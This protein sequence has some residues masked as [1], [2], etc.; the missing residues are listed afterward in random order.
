MT[1]IHRRFLRGVFR[2][3]LVGA[4]L[5][6]IPYAVFVVPDG[7]II[8]AGD[9][10]G[11]QLPAR[12][13]AR[14][15]FIAGRLPLWIG[16]SCGTSLHASQQVGLAYLPMTLAV[17]ALST[18]YGIKLNIFLHV[19]VCYWGQYKL[20]RLHGIS[21][22][23]SSFAA[24]V[25]CQSGFVVFH[26]LEGHVNLV[27]VYALVPWFFWAL[28]KLLRAPSATTTV[29]MAGITALMALGG[30]PQILYY[31]V[32][33]GAL[34][35]GG[36]LVYYVFQGRGG[37]T[38]FSRQR[39][40][41]QLNGLVR[42]RCQ[43]PRAKHALRLLGW[44][45]CAAA[46]TILLIAIQQLPA[47]E[48]AIDGQPTSQ[49]GSFEY[50]GQ[51]AARTVDCLTFWWPT[52]M[53]SRRTEALEY[54]N[55]VGNV[56]ER[57]N[58]LGLAVPLL[59]LVGLA[60]KGDSPIFPRGLGKIGTVPDWQWPIAALVVFCLVF[61]LGP[62]TPVFGLLDYVLPGLYSFRCPARILAI[63]AVLLPLLAARG[64][65]AYIEG[66]KWHTGWKLA[67]AGM[68]AWLAGSTVLDGVWYLFAHGGSYFSHV[69]EHLLVELGIVALLTAGVVVLLVALPAVSRRSVAAAYYLVLFFTAADL[70]VTNGRH[71]ELVPPTPLAGLPDERRSDPN[72]RLAEVPELPTITP[73]RLRYSQLVPAAVDG[74]WTAVFTNEGGVLPQA[75]ERMFDGLM[76]NDTAALR[77][78]ACNWAW[79]RGSW[80]ALPGALPRARFVPQHL[81]ELCA[82]PLTEITAEQVERLAKEARACTIEPEGGS[83]VTVVVEAPSEGVVVL[84]DTFYPGW[85]CRSGGRE[86]PI[87]PAHGTFR[88]VEVPA[89]TRRLEF[90]YEPWTFAVGAG[91]SALGV[92]I[93][94]GLVI[95]DRRQA[96]LLP[97]RS[98]Q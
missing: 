64:L 23:G 68:L 53:G 20:A 85:K 97:A 95:Y 46:L 83:S 5:A 93:S 72:V 54:P 12:E 78:A 73:F 37:Q 88:G 91:M 34:W 75:V 18:N 67:A 19:L 9:Y 81:K 57:T 94:V 56:H 29:M 33:V 4:V 76:Q 17:V 28:V 84:A 27:I 48:L 92:L 62:N 45:S 16:L 14:Q 35:V 21:S 31:C 10:T 26:L 79:V 61:A 89:G 63:V 43:T 15:E 98:T 65:D 22:L 1:V 13:Y 11:F 70:W 3:P 52:Y 7:T 90:S 59:A 58:Y 6:V 25:T 96:R 36:Y 74:Q 51:H 71:I 30:H 38:P 8:G 42:K 86:L 82:V 24:L 77:V 41:G 44:A 39:L 47:V 80:T 2:G 32:L 50:A 66:E 40:V 49:R 87:F 60:K 55:Q 69:Q